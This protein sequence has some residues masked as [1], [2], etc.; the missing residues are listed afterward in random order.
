MYRP[1]VPV[2]LRRAISSE[3]TT[4]YYRLAPVFELYHR[5]LLLDANKFLVALKELKGVCSEQQK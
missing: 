4:G 1:A 2:T 3:T 5:R